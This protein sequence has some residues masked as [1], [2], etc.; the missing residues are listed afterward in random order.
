[1]VR[2]ISDFS[3]SPKKRTQRGEEKKKN[4][5][6]KLD[7]SAHKSDNRYAHTDARAHFHYKKRYESNVRARRVVARARLRLAHV[8]IF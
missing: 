8:E 4:C 2:E 6:H 5:L 7:L 3:F 1:M